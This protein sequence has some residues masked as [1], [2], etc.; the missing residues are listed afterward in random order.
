MVAKVLK[1]GKKT[2]A[3]SVAQDSAVLE[4]VQRKKTLP[5]PFWWVMR[6]RSER[7]RIL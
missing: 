5:M 6:P 7:W 2:V 4:A 3:V 1:C